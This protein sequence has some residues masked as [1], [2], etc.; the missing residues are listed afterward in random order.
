MERKAGLTNGELLKQNIS[1]R[2][3]KVRPRRPK[4]IKCKLNENS[5]PYQSEKN[6]DKSKKLG[7]FL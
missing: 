6:V 1:Q 5:L 3:E 2:N 4:S 7:F